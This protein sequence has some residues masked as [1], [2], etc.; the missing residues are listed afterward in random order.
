MNCAR[1][2]ITN[3]LRFWLGSERQLLYHVTNFIYGSVMNRLQGTDLAW[4]VNNAIRHLSL[5]WLSVFRAT[6]AMSFL[7]LAKNITAATG[8]FRRCSVAGCV[9]SFD[10]WPVVRR[11][12]DGLQADPC[13]YQLR[14]S[15]PCRGRQL[16]RDSLRHL[17]CLPLIY[18]STMRKPSRWLTGRSRLSA[19]SQPYPNITCLFR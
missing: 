11:C 8:S 4:Q 19:G 5:C 15:R 17:Y 6:D 12:P 9:S 3:K 14:F 1:A 16:R 2:G 10:L 13:T 7:P 18:L